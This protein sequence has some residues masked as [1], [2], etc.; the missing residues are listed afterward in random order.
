MTESKAPH[1]QE[2]RKQLEKRTMKVLGTVKQVLD[3]QGGGGSNG[4]LVQ[5]IASKA[6]AT[7]LKHLPESEKAAALKL[8]REMMTC[9][10]LAEIYLG[11]EWTHMEGVVLEEGAHLSYLEGLM[12][13]AAAVALH[14]VAPFRD[15]HVFEKIAILANGREPDF[16][17]TQDLTVPEMAWALT[18]M[19]LI[20][21]R[22]PVDDEV[23][24]YIATVAHNQGWACLPHPLEA[25]TH[26]LMRLMNDQS[27]ARAIEAG[28]YS[29]E[30]GQVQKEK[31]E[32]AD[33]YVHRRMDK[34]HDELMGLVPTI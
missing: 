22:T 5:R 16:T 6:T 34:L 13:K 1:L 3:A 17:I 11:E 29:G 10:F 21:S 32:A 23:L 24:L 18:Q 31:L 8:P 25:A 30:A 20:D 9:A 33:E 27:L 2:Q 15:W 19:K 12:A 14:Q 4:K 26:Y 7:F 28:D